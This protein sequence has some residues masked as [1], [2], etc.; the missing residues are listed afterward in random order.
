MRC[1]RCQHDN[2]PRMKFRGECAAPLASTATL[3]RRESRMG[4]GPAAQGHLT[5][6]AVMSRGMVMHYWA[7]HAQAELRGLG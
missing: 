3:K 5:T 2:P 7:E 4:E 6:G 1:P